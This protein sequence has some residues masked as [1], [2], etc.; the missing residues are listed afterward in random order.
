MKLLHLVSFVSFLPDQHNLVNHMILPWFN[1][2]Q[3]TH[4]DYPL[5]IKHCPRQTKTFISK[6]VRRLLLSQERKTDNWRGK[7]IDF[8]H[9][10]YT[11]K[12]SKSILSIT[13]SANNSYS[14]HLE[15]S[16]FANTLIHLSLF[17]TCRFNWGMLVYIGLKP[18]LTQHSQCTRHWSKHFTHLYIISSNPHNNLIK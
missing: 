9:V 4:I 16:T 14:L 5:C 13:E 1:S 11:S 6:F 10:L 17:V 18:T 7:D 3:Q 2:I 12:R 8:I 15:C